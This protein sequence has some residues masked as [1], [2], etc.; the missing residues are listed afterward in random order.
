MIDAVQVRHPTLIQGGMGVAVSD[1]RLAKAVSECGQ[2]GVVSGT[3]LDTVVARRLQD[4]DPGGHVRRA[5]G[6][7]PKSE[8][9]ERVIACYYIPEGKPEEQSYK[10][11]PMHS[12]KSSQ[13]LTDLTVAANFVEVFL[14]KEGHEGV[15][16]INYLT[17]IDLPTLPSIYGA[18]LAGV[19]YVLMGAGIPRSIPAILDHFSTSCETA[20]LRVEVCGSDSGEIYQVQFDPSRYGCGLS[21]KRPFFIPIVSS[22]TLAQAL[23]KKAP[24][25]I[26]GFVVEHHTAGGHNAPPRGPLNLTDGGEPV[27][28]SKDEPKFDD[29]KKLGLPFWLAGSRASHERLQEAIAF[30]AEG[31]QIG[32]AF[33]YCNESGI[34]SD[35]K[36]RVIQTVMNE[37][38]SV[39][40]D[41][42]ASSSGYPF[43][44]VELEQSLSES[45]VFQLR[46]RICDLG[47]LR[48][49]CKT[50]DGGV[51]FRCAGE[52]IADYV[53]KGGCE[54]DTEGRK[55]LC[56][57]LLSTIGLGQVR[58]DAYAEPPLLTAGNELQ[59]AISTFVGEHKSSYSAREVVEAILSGKSTKV[60]QHVD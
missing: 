48:T 3:M 28:G 38:A 39:F 40:T 27:Y 20:S 44:V 15:V 25:G 56:N 35:L 18:M 54:Q 5:L 21:L 43:K 22:S 59:A 41:P 10:A 47:Y 23:A 19:D 24:G 46:A 4:G 33:A 60:R 52:P 2:L 9:A 50:A 55:C 31:I 30:G 7:F 6:K 12:L 32:T 17:K 8:I 58:K 42:R 11:V 53:R 14:A 49:P 37:K 51:V 26:D 29:F 34:S 1:W 36:A 16:G 45:E 57:G 13:L